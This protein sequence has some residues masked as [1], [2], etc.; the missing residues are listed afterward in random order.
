MSPDDDCYLRL[1]MTALA[2]TRLLF[3][4]V[5]VITGYCLGVTVSGKRHDISPTRQQA[6]FHG[7]T[8]EEEW[9]IG[10]SS[11]VS[12]NQVRDSSLLVPTRMVVSYH[13]FNLFSL[14][15]AAGGSSC[16]EESNGQL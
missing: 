5:V 11:L 10:K 13:I 8:P 3:L 9:H 14:L 2:D 15:C 4:A 12:Q 16:S 1:D 7:L 6:S